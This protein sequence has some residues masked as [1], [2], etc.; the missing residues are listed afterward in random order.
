MP[1][2]EHFCEFSQTVVRKPA[3]PASRR[4]RIAQ[5]TDLH[6]DISSVGQAL[7]TQHPDAYAHL[8]DR[9]T[10]VC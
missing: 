5:S 9:Q 1:W 4:F 10:P 2:N 6:G 7:A 8:P 3:E